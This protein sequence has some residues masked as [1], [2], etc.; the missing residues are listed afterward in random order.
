MPNQ[1]FVIIEDKNRYQFHD[2][3]KRIFTNDAEKIL[4]RYDCKYVLG[5]HKSTAKTIWNKIRKNQHA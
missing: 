1:F 2:F 5:F 3:T 4:Q